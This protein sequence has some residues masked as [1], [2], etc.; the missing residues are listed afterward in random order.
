MWS[1]PIIQMTKKPHAIG[2][3]G[4]TMG[5]SKTW[6]LVLLDYLFH[7]SGFIVYANHVLT[8]PHKDFWDVY[9]NIEKFFKVR[10]A[11]LSADDANALPGFE[12][13]R[14]TDPL[15]VMLSHFAQ[16]CRKRNLYFLF[17][18]PRLLWMDVRLWDLAT[19]H[20]YSDHM[21]V[22]GEEMVK[23]EVLDKR[24]T[25]PKFYTRWFHA[26]PVYPL[27]DTYETMAPAALSQKPE[28]SNVSV[29]GKPLKS[30]VMVCPRCNTSSRL[31]YNR[32]LGLQYC[33]KCGWEREIK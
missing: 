13:R 19:V 2:I 26:E 17:S 23:W 4:P 28:I 6:T 9:G 27:Y 10:D 18:A 24:W 1:S 8:F 15:N 22:D 31:N 33:S 7:K 29:S 5:S 30:P 25:P 32:K 12:S 21:L 16:Q 14:P 11:V 20:I 3:T